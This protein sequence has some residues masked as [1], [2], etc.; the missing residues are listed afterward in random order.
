MDTQRLAQLLPWLLLLA[1][2]IGRAPEATAQTDRYTQSMQLGFQQMA[3]DSFLEAYNS[4]EAARVFATRPYNEDSVLQAI[5][6]RENALSG[7][8]DHIRS[9]KNIENFDFPRQYRRAE[10]QR[11][12]LLAWREADRQHIEDATT[13]ILLSR[14]LAVEDPDMDPSAVNRILGTVFY[15]RYG[16]RIGQ[17]GAALTLARFSP[18]S[19]RLFTVSRDKALRIWT[20]DGQPLGQPR[21]HDGFIRSAVFSEDG[22]QLITAATDHRIYRWTVDQ[23][24]AVGALSGHTDEVTQ[25][26][27]LD[28][29]DQALSAGRD[30]TLRRWDLSAQTG[31]SLLPPSAPIQEITAY[32]AEQILVRESDKAVVVW[33]PQKPYPLK[34]RGYIYSAV[35]SSDGRLVLTASADSTARLWNWRENTYLT[36]D[37][38]R[39]LVTKARFNHRGD[40][41]ATTS[42]DGTAILWTSAGD[43][44]RTLTGHQGW[45]VDAAFSADDR[46]LFTRDQ[47]A[48]LH[49]WDA[50]GNLVATLEGHEAPLLAAEFSPDGLDKT[51]VLTASKDGTAK[52]WDERGNL[53]LNLDGFQGP[54]V[55]ASFSPDGRY[56]LA[57]SE[58]G[59][60]VICP[61]PATLLP[62]L[63]AQLELSEEQMKRYGINAWPPFLKGALPG[64]DKP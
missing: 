37:R 1:A 11:L 35:F 39:G 49:L 2:L 52:L 15:R 28:Q 44:I 30:G 46:L 61:L 23:D 34:H 7:L 47:G 26:V 24:A 33:T 21:R 18:D 12:A 36:L 40:R 10:V 58:D 8:G 17:P 22:N 9:L 59:A 55:T 29:T 50:D 13:L 56:L 41:L 42:T 51:Y 43:T 19:R 38:H 63:D 45:V 27:F 25:A 54:V 60:A 57:A 20:V 4:F 32:T 14:R 48:S 16:I 5:T 31:T 6:Y 3:M 62:Q 53:L 64:G